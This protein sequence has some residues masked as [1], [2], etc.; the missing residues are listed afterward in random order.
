MGLQHFGQL[1]LVVLVVVGFGRGVHRQ[2]LEQRFDQLPFVD[3]QVVVLN[4][5][6]EIDERY[7][8]EVDVRVCHEQVG[9]V[10]QDVML[11][12]VLQ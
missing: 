12:E 3:V 1:L 6:L 11:A 10:V 4:Q 7:F 5:P 9:R 2:P 8:L